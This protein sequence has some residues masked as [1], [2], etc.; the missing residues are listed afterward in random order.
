MVAFR[1][2]RGQHSVCIVELKSQDRYARS[3]GLLQY[4]PVAIMRAVCFSTNLPTLAYSYHRLMKARYPAMAPLRCT[5]FVRL[6]ALNHACSEKWPLLCMILVT[7]LARPVRKRSNLGAATLIVPVIVTFVAVTRRYRF[8]Y[9]TPLLHQ[10][11]V[12]SLQVVGLFGTIS[13]VFSHTS[14]TVL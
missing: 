1:R 3:P 7:H 4:M 9:V 5:V 13:W 14:T 12:A 10:L 6:S 2:A 8:G 11:L